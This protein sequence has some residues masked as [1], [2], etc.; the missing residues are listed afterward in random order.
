MLVG[1]VE[2]PVIDGFIIG[3]KQQSLAVVIEPA[4]RIYI[5]RDQCNVFEGAFSSFAGELR[6]HFKW[7]VKKKVIRHKRKKNPPEKSGGLLCGWVSKYR[8]I[9][10]PTQY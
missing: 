8:E 5:Y 3:K 9:N 2:Q 6:K 7:F 10:F 1:R 4:Y